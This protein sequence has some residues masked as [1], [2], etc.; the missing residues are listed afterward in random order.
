MNKLKK[1]INHYN[2]KGWVIYRNL[3][4]LDEINSVNQLINDYLKNKIK[5]VNKKSRAINFTDIIKLV[6]KI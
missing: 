1:L 5:T 6:L 4:S 3:F 2:D